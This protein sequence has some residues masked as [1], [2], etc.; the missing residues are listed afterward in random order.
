MIFLGVAQNIHDTQ[1]RLSVQGF[2]KKAA[3]F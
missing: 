2:L 1:S 3:D